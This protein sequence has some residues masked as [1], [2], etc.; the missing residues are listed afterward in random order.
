MNEKEAEKL[1]ERVRLEKEKAY[2]SVQQAL[3]DVERLRFEA[4][5]A[6]QEQRT[7]AENRSRQRQALFAGGGNSNTIST[8]TFSTPLSTVLEQEADS[9]AHEL[10]EATQAT[11]VHN[12]K[13]AILFSVELYG[14]D[15]IPGII[16]QPRAK[17]KVSFRINM[18]K[19]SIEINNKDN[20]AV[21]GVDMYVTSPG[22]NDYIGLYVCGTPQTSENAA[23]NHL[24]LEYTNAMTFGEI[25]LTLPSDQLKASLPHD[26]EI[27]Y[28]HQSGRI[29]AS[30]GPIH[31]RKN[32]SSTSSASASVP[33]PIPVQL[34]IPHMTEEQHPG[35]DTSEDALPITLLD[36]FYN[37]FNNTSSL[38][39]SLQPKLGIRVFRPPFLL[40]KL[41]RISAYQIY[42]PLPRY[43]RTMRPIGTSQ[44]GCSEDSEISTSNVFLRLPEKWSPGVAIEGDSSSD[45]Y[46]GLHPTVHVLFEL[47]QIQRNGSEQNTNG[48]CAYD[49][50]A[51]EIHDT[52]R[53][54][55]VSEI[56]ALP[57]DLFRLSLRLQ[58]RVERS[59]CTMKIH[60]DHII[61]RLPMYYGGAALPDRPSS[62]ISLDEMLS[63]RR[64]GTALSC[65]E[66]SNRLLKENMKIR[67]P[68]SFS[69]SSSSSSFSL[70]STSIFDS[71]RNEYPNGMRSFVLPSEY[72]LEWS[73][74]WLCHESQMNV[75]IPDVDFGAMQGVLLV[76][77][78]HIQAHP[79]D[80]ALDAILLRP[81]CTPTK[82]ST[83]VS[84]TG[85]SEENSTE[86]V[87]CTIECARCSSNLGTTHCAVPTAARSSPFFTLTP[88]KSSVQGAYLA[89]SVDIWGP[90]LSPDSD[91][92]IRLHKDRISVPNDTE[93]TEP[94]AKAFN[95]FRAKEASS[96][97]S[98]SSSTSSSSQLPR[99]R[100]ALRNYSVCSR[101]AAELLAASHSRAQYK[102]LL[103]ATD[104]DT[105]S[106]TMSTN[107]KQQSYPVGTCVAITLVNWNI[108][109]RGTTQHSIWS[110]IEQGSSTSSGSLRRWEPNTFP[111]ADVPALQ[112]LFHLILDSK[113]NDS[114][115]AAL[116]DWQGS[117]S[118][119]AVPLLMDEI[120]IV[121]A[122]LLESCLLF[123]RNA[124]KPPQTGLTT[125]TQSLFRVGF[126]PL[127][128]NFR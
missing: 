98:S 68:P 97:S 29:L 54:K 93:L 47:P 106:G 89:E 82:D 49:A 40:Q 81:I 52:T 71:T 37:S 51:T 90:K 88:S 35:H 121:T 72:W 59:K 5:K 19:T 10:E 13:I 103:V 111:G 11:Q 24:T 30:C 117:V 32:T 73:D 15:F 28:V 60:S 48:V 76:G 6:E 77:E 86:F 69:S 109:I 126:L 84:A 56:A 118:A 125:T 122:V 92:V 127:L 34:S 87:F 17:V 31:M 55:S 116:D 21:D 70:T 57:R 41:V 2:F 64:Q 113:M 16:L 45:L 18:S 91:P 101:L 66:C 78:I 39:H 9:L 75:L 1:L 7:A 65:R 61:L 102:F 115:I 100:N 62:L 112:V 3:K 124:Q 120:E 22:E 110:E 8:N 12:S 44:T 63:L 123:P 119:T 74:F 27:W 53:N 20:A 107:S 23:S 94:L 43:L 36:K 114:E 105:P 83:I 58:H 46:D 95:E 38:S 79:A 33:I 14:N 50:T 4:D 108:S 85:L 25:I 128:E 26:F 80:F 67:T 104:Y 96:S 99:S 42:I